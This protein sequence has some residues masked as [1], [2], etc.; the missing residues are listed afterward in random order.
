MSLSPEQMISHLDASIERRGQLVKLI[1]WSTGPDGKRI[2]FEVRFKANVRE[3][4]P[5][6][7]VEQG[8]DTVV[9]I[10]PTSLEAARFPGVPRKDDH[11]IV[12]GD[13]P[14]D[15]QRITPIRV[16]DVLVRVRV[17]CRG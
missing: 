6:D 11:L 16:D 4:G 3:A 12:F 5:S 14:A 17:I 8:G 2:P 1:R 9:V 7:L 13:N 15:I 10:S